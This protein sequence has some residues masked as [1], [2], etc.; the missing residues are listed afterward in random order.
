MSWSLFGRTILAG[1]AIVMAVVPLTFLLSFL[2]WDV[3]QEQEVQVRYLAWAATL[4]KD[5]AFVLVSIVGGALGGALHVLASLTW[6]L[7]HNTFDRRWT[8]WFLTNPLMGAGL[9][10]AFLFVLQA[11]LGQVS[12]S[13]S[14]LYGVASIA[15]LSGL[16]TQHALGKLKDIFDAAFAGKSG[17]MAAAASVP[18]ITSVQ[19][20]SWDGSIELTGTGFTDD[21]E[22]WHGDTK[23]P[24]TRRTGT[25][26]TIPLP[27]GVQPGTSARLR[28][29]SSGGI[30]SNEAEVDV[31]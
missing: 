7:A 11:G 30:W 19:W 5:Q 24:P 26:I 31:R 21:S 9:A 28:V 13:A 6:H 25:S 22:V 1:I 15:T 23:V 3:G 18:I 27:Q 29:R 10:T 14:S 2:G 16:F 12:S 17:Q 8:F 20:R 4:P